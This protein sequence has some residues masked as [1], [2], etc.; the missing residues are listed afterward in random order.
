MHL[1]VKSDARGF[2]VLQMLQRRVR[3]R[4]AENDARRC[5]RSCRSC[6]DLGGH[7]RFARFKLSRY[8][9]D[10]K[11]QV[12]FVAAAIVAP[13]VCDGAQ[14][15]EDRS[16]RYVN[17]E[18][19]PAWEKRRRSRPI[20]RTGASYSGA[21]LEHDTTSTEIDDTD[22]QGGS[23]LRVIR[24]GYREFVGSCDADGLDGELEESEATGTGHSR[25]TLTGRHSP[26]HWP[27]LH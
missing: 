21:A 9:E 15:D 8:P 20:D 13:S 5:R 11:W 27:G 14:S 3:S 26:V 19:S 12:R 1:T 16:R 6:Q 23:Y 2:R 4:D 18:K 24:I 22:V 25:S 10:G 7:R 17:F